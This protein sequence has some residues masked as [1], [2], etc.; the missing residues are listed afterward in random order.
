MREQSVRTPEIETPLRDGKVSRGTLWEVDPRGPLV[1]MIHGLTS[2]RN[3]SPLSVGARQLAAAG[4]STYRPDLYSF[5]DDTR[6][7]LECDVDTHARDIEDIAVQLRRQFPGR[8]L[9]ALGHSLGGLS[10]VASTARFDG[11]VL[12][13]ASHPSAYPFTRD[14]ALA[15]RVPG[16]WIRWRADLGCYLTTGAIST[17]LSRELLASVKRPANQEIRRVEEPLLIVWAEGGVLEAG[18]REYYDS[19]TA[20]HRHLLKAPGADHC[21]DKFGT[22]ERAFAD[23]ASWVKSI[24]R[25]AA[26]TPQPVGLTLE[27]RVS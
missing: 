7:L 25:T 3:S 17:L 10:L 27:L 23:I 20:P 2:D 15:G 16:D 22:A 8:Q 6:T 1:M 21:F 4:I 24:E 5:G 26:P 9:I 11:L 12:L 18:A 19:A 13:D 14:D